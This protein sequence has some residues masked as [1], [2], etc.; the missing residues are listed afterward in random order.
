[1]KRREFFKGSAVA[2]ASLAIGSRSPGKTKGAPD[3]LP[4]LDAKMAEGNYL[5]YYVERE[6]TKPVDLCDEQGLLNPDAIG[7]SRIPLHRLN[8]SGNWPH[9]K[10]WNWWDIIS[11]RFNFMFLIANIDYLGL[12]V[13][14]FADFETKESFMSLVVPPL[15]RGCDMPEYVEEDISFD[16]GKTRMS[17]LYRG[18]EIKVDYH[19][20]CLGGEKISAD[21]VIHKPKDHETLN[22]VIPWTRERFNF[23]SKQNTMPTEGTVTV[24]GKRYVMDPEDC[25]AV[26]DFC[27]GMWPYR[28]FWNWAVC[29]GKQGK[30]MIGFNMGAKWTTGTG[31]N[32]N[33]ICY[34]GKL[35]KVMEDVKWE[36]DIKTPKKPWRIRTEHSDMVDVTLTPVIS[37]DDTLHKLNLG[38]LSLYGISGHGHWS[39]T[40]KL[41]GKTIKLEDSNLMG[42]AEE[43]GFKW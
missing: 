37:S 20:K 6:L 14:S 7:W 24:G 16:N 23:T 34:N 32:E 31:Y 41:D 2:A 30:D 5:P 35:Y 4:I 40:L 10:K 17:M 29:S 38:M 39:G 21:L 15:G 8:L 1:M 9:K 25:H 26:Q 42:W 33:G 27:R 12:A 18:E 19:G 3:Y 22:V 28:T 11:P 36:Y 13:S 43:C